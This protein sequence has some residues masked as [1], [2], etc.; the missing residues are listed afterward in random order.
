MVIGIFLTCLICFAV[1]MWWVIES[2]Y[3]VK[4]VK[5]NKPAIKKK[6]MKW[7]FNKMFLK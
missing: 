7:G 4:R 5:D 2:K 6:Q 1:M 3:V